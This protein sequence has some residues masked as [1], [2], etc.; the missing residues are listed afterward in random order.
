VHITQIEFE[1][2]KSF[3]KKIKIPFFDGFTTISGPNGSG[4]SNIIDGILFC[5]GLSGSRTMRAE[6]LT[7]LIYNGGGKKPDYA[8]VTIKIDNSQREIPSKKDSIT[9]T[10][11]IRQTESGYYSYYYLDGKAV[12]LQEL[13][14]LLGKAKITPEGYNVVMQGDVTRIIEMTPFERRKIIDE[15]AGVSEFDSKK[16]RALNEL[17]IVRERI[18][19]VDIILEE[20]KAQLQRLAQ[21]RG[22]ALKYKA[23]REERRRYEGFIILARLRDAREELVSLE[24]ELLEKQRAQ[25]EV[26]RRYEK[27]ENTLQ[28]L[29]TQLQELNKEIYQM[30]EAEQ[31]QIKKQIEEIKAGKEVA[32]STIELI[33]REIASGDELKR[34]SLLEINTLQDKIQSLEEQIAEEQLRKETLQRELE[35]KQT[36]ERLV[37]SKIAQ[38]DAEYADTQKTLTEL[39]EVVEALKEERNDLMRQEDRLLDVLRRKTSQAREIEAEI[40][41]AQEKIDSE[42]RDTQRL[43]EEIH[44]LNHQLKNQFSDL[45]DLEKIRK[46]L[47][48]EISALERELVKFQQEHMRLEAKIKAAREVS[49]YSSA[50][51][52][53]LKA[54]KNRELEGIYGTIAELGKT[55][56]RYSTAL[57]IAAGARIQSI[58]VATDEDAAYAIA[59]LKQRRRG[60]A[61]FLPLNKLEPKRELEAPQHPGVIDYAV[62]LIEYDSKFDPAFWY[63]FRDT[64]IVETLS[65]ARRLM[66]RYRMV[67][68]EGDLIERGGAMTGGSVKSRL[69]FASDESEKLTQL[70]QRITE[71]ESRK[72]NTLSRLDSTESHIHA[73]QKEIAECEKTLSRKQ[74][75]L[76]DV[77][78]RGKRLAELIERRREELQ[79]MQQDRETIRVEMEQVEETKKEKN[80][81][82]SKIEQQISELENRIKDSP[83]PRLNEQLSSL[84]DETNH[85]KGRIHDVEAQLNNLNLERKYAEDKISEIKNRIAEIEHKKTEHTTRIQQ[86]QQQIEELDQ[87]LTLK[88]E[89]EAQLAIELTQKQQERDKLQKNRDDAKKQTLNIEAE[90]K[91]L[92]NQILAVNATRDALKEQITELEAEIKQRSLIETEDVPTSEQVYT[93]IKSIERAMER[94]EPVNMRAIDEYNEVEVRQKELQARRDTLFREREELLQRIANCEQMKKDAFMEAYQHINN[95]FKEIF[96]EL[97]DGSGE[98]ILENPEDPFAGGLTIRARPAEKAEQRLEAMSGGE[99]SLTALAL[100]FAIQQYRPAPFYAFDEIDMFLDGANAE[101]VAKRIKKSSKDAQFIVVSLRKPMIEAAERTLGVTMQ[102]DNITTITGV[103]IK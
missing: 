22:Q 41:E 42:E 10:R 25:Q 12:T 35:D 32:S 20:V 31:I 26:Q 92:N 14:E 3:G 37:K 33:N 51:E 50:V 55:D 45:E 91:Q 94:L 102:E 84:Q 40:S 86:L 36:Q 29:E 98:I 61:T 97:S 17:E 57:E 19:R 75:E 43:T 62:N 59:Y 39:K 38:V 4:K 89:R 66:G 54:K 100:I 16:E 21:E 73:L 56:K 68:L 15:I 23:L 46:D 52:S 67:T 24:E 71:L 82:I 47:K 80:S 99:K 6:K 78:G 90:I 96:A 60:R 70:A 76:D 18:E 2:F 30:G 101:R 83:L 58:I 53:I 63:V 85:L 65:D 81:E 27:W 13:H 93:R 8:L 64:L 48:T 88:K 77:K 28:A 69:G 79:Q 95:H 103:K 44:S 72:N 11:K 49:G 34:K 7:D 74:L 1:N 5:L 9:I 87:E